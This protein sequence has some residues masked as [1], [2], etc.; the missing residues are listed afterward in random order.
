[1]V[2][3]VVLRRRQPQRFQQRSFVFGQEEDV[4][5]EGTILAP[6]EPGLLLPGDPNI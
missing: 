1:V 3:T 5:T 6:V 2:W 4:P